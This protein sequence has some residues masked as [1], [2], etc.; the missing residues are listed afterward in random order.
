MNEETMNYWRPKMDTIKDINFVIN[1]PGEGMDIIKE[2][3]MP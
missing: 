2:K 3:K 1:R